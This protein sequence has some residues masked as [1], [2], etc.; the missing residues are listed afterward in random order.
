MAK[1]NF[2]RKGSEITSKARGGRILN[3]RYAAVRRR[4]GTAVALSSPG[5]GLQSPVSLVDRFGRKRRRWP[6]HIYT[7]LGLFLSKISP[8]SLWFDLQ[9]CYRLEEE[10]KKKILEQVSWPEVA[11]IVR[12]SRRKPPG[13]VAGRGFGPRR[14]RTGFPE[15][16]TP[17]NPNL[18]FIVSFSST[19]V[20]HNFFIRTPIYAC[21]V[22]TNLV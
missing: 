10:K 13:T 17:H 15:M 12:K 6:W 5:Q 3:L 21:F 7:I 11:G 8:S 20:D 16:E 14:E 19:S 22:S 9:G 1:S 2:D 18:L 4:L